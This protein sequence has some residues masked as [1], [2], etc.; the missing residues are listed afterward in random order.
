MKNSMVFPKKFKIDLFLVIINCVPTVG[1]S[2][3][4]LKSGTWA[5]I[6]TL[7]FIVEANQLFI[8]G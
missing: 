7:V 6:F 3:K 1:I 4:E 8:D 2:S 5:N